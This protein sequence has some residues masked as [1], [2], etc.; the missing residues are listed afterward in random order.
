MTTDSG[1]VPLLLITGPVGAGK[2]TV[3]GEVSA[4]LEQ[5]GVPHAFVD[6]DH[7]RWAYPRLLADRFNVALGLRNLAAV[8]ANYRAAGATHL[9]LADV[10]ERREA[11]AGYAA[12]VP[13]AAI[14]VVRLRAA[15]A[16][17]HG[18]VRERETGAG[19]AWHLDRSAEL[20]AQMERDRLEDFAVETDGRPVGAIAREVLDRSGWLVPPPG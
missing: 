11:L 3:A 5:T 19:L 18:R 12:A 8:W 15:V 7:L 2:T 10:L 6:L 14:T 16:T 13:G 1:T 17:L 4:L 9:I 20:A